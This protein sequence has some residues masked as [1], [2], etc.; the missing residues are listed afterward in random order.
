MG[1]KP[2][3]LYRIDEYGDWFAKL[4]RTIQAYEHADLDANDIRNRQKQVQIVQRKYKARLRHLEWARAYKD[5]YN[6]VYT[7]KLSKGYTEDEAFKEARRLAEIAVTIKFPKNDKSTMGTR[8]VRNALNRI[9]DKVYMTDI[10]HKD[11]YETKK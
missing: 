2:K 9:N 7:T 6:S 1:K 8:T 10:F 4:G 11:I 5:K 3:F